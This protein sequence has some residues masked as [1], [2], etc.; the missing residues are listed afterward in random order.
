[1]TRQFE[2]RAG[3]VADGIVDGCFN[4]QQRQA[5]TPASHMTLARDIPGNSFASRTAILAAARPHWRRGAE[6]DRR[7]TTKVSQR[8]N[9]DGMSQ[10][11]YSDL[12]QMLDERRR[13]IQAE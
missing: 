2:E 10:S 12:K 3:D 8:E 1:M 11:R 6:G 9:S 4:L 7:M 5:R 13:E